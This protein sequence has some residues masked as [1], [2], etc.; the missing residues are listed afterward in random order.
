MNSNN[1][2]LLLCII[3]LLILC[4]QSSSTNHV[5]LPRYCAIGGVQVFVKIFANSKRYLSK[6]LY[7]YS[8]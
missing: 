3:N 1:A 7:S 2:G 4:F 6:I 5:Y 8:L